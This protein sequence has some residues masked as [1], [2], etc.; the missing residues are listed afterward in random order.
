MPCIPCLIALGNPGRKP[1]KLPD[2]GALALLGTVLEIEVERDSDGAVVQHKWKRRG[3]PGLLWSPSLKAILIFPGN[4]ELGWDP[5]SFKQRVGRFGVKT[6]RRSSAKS[7]LK[8]K[9]ESLR[10]G[11]DPDDAMWSALRGESA[12]MKLFRRWAM[13][14]STGRKDV[15]IRP[16]TMRP[17]G[18]AKHVVYWSDKWGDDAEYVHKF[19]PNVRMAMASGNPPKAIALAGGRLTVTE[20][21]LV[22]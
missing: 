21:G 3:A 16:Y 10:S 13:R 8:R 7:F 22:Y 19:S 2:P 15:S 18:R 4:R 20:R 1:S 9:R 6:L 17:Y 12:A 11:A 5:G 14:P